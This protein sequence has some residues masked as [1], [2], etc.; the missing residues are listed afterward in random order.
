MTIE[1]LVS[2]A[3]LFSGRRWRA[4]SEEGREEEAWLWSRLQDLLSLALGTGQFYRFE[5]YLEG[6]APDARPVMSPLLEAREDSI[7]SRILEL[8][9]RTW[10]EMPEPRPRRSVRVLASLVNFIADTGQFE[11]GEDYMKNRLEHAPLAV[12][13]FATR[14]EAEAWLKGLAEPPSPS[15]ILIGDEYHEAWCPREKGT[16]ELFRVHAIEPY[17]EG[18][19]ARGIPPGVPSFE[20]R[21]EAEAWLASHPV[22]PFGFVSVAGERHFAV[23][24]KRLK[25]H[26]LHHVAT[27]LGVWE[28]EKKR[29]ATYQPPEEDEDVE[30]EEEDL[31]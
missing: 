8:L 27:A 17:I 7:S 5:A 28:E 24:H 4:A 12:A 11:D 20:S 6:V 21:G 1:V 15:Y 25:L 29:L 26:T 3:S 14:G 9:Q 13:R 18:F 19:T 22:N 10:D 30:E 2:R 23:H 31:D 16:R